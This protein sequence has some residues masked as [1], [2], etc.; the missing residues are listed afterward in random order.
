MERSLNQDDKKSQSDLDRDRFE[1]EK[2]IHR[3]T[4]E[5]RKEELAQKRENDQHSRRLS[6]SPLL[7]AAVTAVFALL[8]TAIA[9]VAQS[10]FNRQLERERFDFTKEIDR[11]KQRADLITKAIGTGNLS[12]AASNLRF[13]VTSGLIDDPD[14]KILLATKNPDTTPVLPRPDG[15]SQTPPPSRP[16]LTNSPRVSLD[17]DL[18]RIALEKAR[19][20]IGVLEQ[21][22]GS[23]RGPEIDKYLESVGLTTGIG[24]SVAFVY[25]C[26]E[27]AS[28]AGGSSNPLPRNASV[29]GMLSQLD[30]KRVK[31]ITSKAA[32]QNPELIKPGMIFVMD[33]GGGI[34]HVG[35]VESRNGD[36]ITTIE[37]NS[38]DSGGRDG[39]GVFRIS[40]KIAT[41]NRGFIGVN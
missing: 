8:G 29:G 15:I 12:D 26:F 11:Q 4:A 28:V 36:S 40:R 16:P 37:G 41:V 2:A 34:G 18:S 14:G 24:W 25:W 13:L 23:N 17:V 27:Q 20:Q 10:Y 32:L 33:F 30:S 31:Q 5:L 22:P 3:E 39:R 1:W 38:N 35:I 21:P 19:S 6:A 9:A 7:A